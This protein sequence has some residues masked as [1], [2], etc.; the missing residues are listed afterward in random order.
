MEN[1]KFTFGWNLLLL[2]MAILLIIY[3]IHNYNYAKEI[4]ENN[5]AKDCLE[6]VNLKIVDKYKEY[7][8]LG[9]RIDYYLNL[10]N[11]E[12]ALEISEKIYLQTKIDSIITEKMCLVGVKS[13]NF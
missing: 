3:A 1:K 5:Y 4:K 13:K 7:H 11:T 10:E 12:N 2:L 9:N 6:K 8:P